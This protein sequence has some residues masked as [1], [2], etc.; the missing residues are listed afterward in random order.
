MALAG[1]HV[2]DRSQNLGA[3]VG[4]GSNGKH[5]RGRQFLRLRGP[6]TGHA[7]SCRGKSGELRGQY[8]LGPGA[9]L[10]HQ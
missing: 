6:A 9:A 5:L 10:V 8:H 4:P 3:N 1:L 2:F 7:W